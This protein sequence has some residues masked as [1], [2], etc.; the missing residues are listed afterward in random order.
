MLPFQATGFVSSVDEGHILA[1]IPVEIASMY[2][3]GPRPVLFTPPTYD[4]PGEW[5][6]LDPSQRV[7]AA[8]A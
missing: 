4:Q 6:I 2:A 3:P 8:F 5:Q 1:E 7:A